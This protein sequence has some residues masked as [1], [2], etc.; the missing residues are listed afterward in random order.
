MPQH[1][2]IVGRASHRHWRHR[3]RGQQ[4]PSV[5]PDIDYYSFQG[6]RGNTVTIDIDFGFKGAAFSATNP[7][8]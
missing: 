1:L 6:T 3:R 2:D 5:V 4:A 7:D 8:R